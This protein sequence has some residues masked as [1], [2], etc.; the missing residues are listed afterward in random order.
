MRMKIVV[1]VDESEQA[2]R[3]VEWCANYAV[4]L[5]AE[6]V[7]IHA[8]DIGFYASPVGSVVPALL[9]PDDRENL[10][11]RIT[12]EWCAPLANANVPYRVVLMDGDPAP[13]IIKA[14]KTEPADL[15]VVGRRGRGGFAELLLGGTS[16]AL[17]HHL[18]RPL[19]IVP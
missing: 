4:T 9:A 19:L 6:V 2:N 13:A 1:G 17:V 7:V 5:D 3:A 15:V 11:D 16:Y 14:A 10:R 8:I 18:A 12:N